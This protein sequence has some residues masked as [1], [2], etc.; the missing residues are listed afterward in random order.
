MLSYQAQLASAK[1][2]LKMYDFQKQKNLGQQGEERLDSFFSR[3]Y[4]IKEVPF[5]LQQKGIDRF[6]IPR[7][8]EA[9]FPRLV[10]YKTDFHRTNN[11]FL[12]THSVIRQ[13]RP[14]V[15]GWLYTSKADWLIYFLTAYQTALV[16]DFVKLRKSARIWDKTCQH[17]DCKNKDYKSSGLLVPI[18]ELRLISHA[19]FDVEYVASKPK[20]TPHR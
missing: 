2:G 1:L 5:E 14:D 19:V 13:G 11:V 18:P 7:R 15:K 12:E 4:N 8:G 16:I 10:E 20:V 9:T 17:R 6:Y 3:W